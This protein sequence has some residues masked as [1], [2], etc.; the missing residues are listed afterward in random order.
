MTYR[1]SVR[2]LSCVLVVLSLVAACAP[3]EQSQEILA[4]S[5]GRS[6]VSK[7]EACGQIGTSLAASIVLRSASGHDKTII[8]YVPN[9]GQAGCKWNLFPRAREGDAVTVDWSNPAA[10]H[11][12]I[13]VVSSIADKH[14]EVD[15]VHITYDIGTVISEACKE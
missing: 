7:F 8:N 2:D 13:G 12:L 10:I 11:I 3:C 15:G 14:D 9:G 4:K 6:V 1:V 5:N